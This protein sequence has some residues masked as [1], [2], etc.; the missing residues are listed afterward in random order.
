MKI[1]NLKNLIKPFYYNFKHITNSHPYRKYNK[2]YECIFIHIPKT[3]GTSIL[4]LLNN[5]ETFRYHGFWYEYQKRSPHYFNN[6]YK[7]SFVRNPWDRTVSTYFYL[8]KLIENSKTTFIPKNLDKYET[9]DEFVNLFLNK[10]TIWSHKLFIPQWFFILDQDDKL[11]VDFLGK[12]ENIEEDFDIIKSNFK[13]NPDGQLMKLNS[14]QRK[15]YNYY[16]TDKTK[17]KIAELY[18]KD[19]KYFNYK[20]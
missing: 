7:F 8:R 12:Y 1:N 10:D 11:K 5:N 16:Y 13:Y 18:S 17:S 4:K 3:A 15:K 20:F 6:F 14:S 19:I 2:K 9:F